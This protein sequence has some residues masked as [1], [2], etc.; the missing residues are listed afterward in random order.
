MPVEVPTNGDDKL[1]VTLCI[2]SY[3]LSSQYCK[4]AVGEERDRKSTT[5][6]QSWFIS[7]DHTELRDG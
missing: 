2:V 5:K 4:H 7:E 1:T 3:L 6:G